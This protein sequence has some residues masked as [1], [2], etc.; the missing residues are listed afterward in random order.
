MPLEK[1]IV[2][3]LLPLVSDLLQARQDRGALGRREVRAVVVR[4]VEGRCQRGGDLAPRALS[5]EAAHLGKVEPLG[6]RQ[7]PPECVEARVGPGDVWAGDV[8]VSW[9]QNEPHHILLAS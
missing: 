4:V 1:W 9:E 3:P 8:S 2:A 7:P 6:L 5:T